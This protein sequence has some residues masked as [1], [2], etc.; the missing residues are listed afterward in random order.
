MEAR[1]SGAERSV[2]TKCSGR[3]SVSEGWNARPERSEGNARNKLLTFI[4]PIV[5]FLV[6]IIKV[7]TKSFTILIGGTY[8]NFAKW[9]P[10]LK[11]SDF[12]IYMATVGLD[13]KPKVRPVQFMVEYDGKLW[14]C[15]NSKKSMYAELV[16]NPWIDLCGSKL[17]EN[18]IQTTWIRL[19][20][21]AVFEE[22]LEVKKMIMEKSAIVHELYENN[23]EHPLFKV[24]YLKNIRGSLNNLGHV[25]GLSKRADFA[26]PKEFEF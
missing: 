15:T 13:G 8:W 5:I 11:K 9:R 19:S 3:M 1:S 12:N 22:N 21:E 25:K 14:F 2:R 6:V 26:K 7:T 17:L 18:E 23:A 10:V 20:A 16:K 4:F 24:F